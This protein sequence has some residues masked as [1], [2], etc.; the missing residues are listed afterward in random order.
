MR[1]ICVKRCIFCKKDSS[2]SRSVEH[3]IPESLGNTTLMLQS[4]VVCDKCNNY[5]S[6]K[7]EAAFLNSPQLR[8]LRFDQHITNK[9]GRIPHITGQLKHGGK[10]EIHKITDSPF[11]AH[12]F[13]GN[14]SIKDMHRSEDGELLIPIETTPPDSS[15]TSRFLAKMG[16]EALALRF[17]ESPYPGG[18]EYIVDEAQFDL[19]RDH[20]R[21]GKNTNW[22]VSVRKIYEIER[23]F[24]EGSSS[25]LQTIHEHNFLKTKYD[26][27]YFVVIIFDV[28]FAINIGGPEIE[29]YNIWLTENDN[30]SPLY[31]G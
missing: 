24:S 5:F 10:V 28:E 23:T 6:R 16:L 15:T 13:L 8:N 7:I 30:S 9:R 4:G 18:Q 31:L 20:A 14:N 26:E 2:S 3:I 25:V 1:V 11:A 19:I 29:G 21:I 22:P 27:I 17:I 12:I